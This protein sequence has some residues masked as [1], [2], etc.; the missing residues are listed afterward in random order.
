MVQLLVTNWTP[1]LPMTAPSLVGRYVRTDPLDWTKDVPLFGRAL[2]GN[3][4]G[5]I[6]KRLQWYG[7]P[8]LETEDDLALLLQKIE[9]SMG[10]CVNI[11]R[12]GKSKNQEGVVA[13]MV[14]FIATRAEHGYRRYEWKCDSHNIPL[15][16][17]AICYGFTYEGCFRQHVVTANKGNNR[18][19]MDSEWPQRK[20]A[21]KAWLGTSNF[22]ADGKQKQRIQD[23]QT[24]KTKEPAG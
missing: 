16:N 23:F 21:M 10:C 13:G 18:D 6:S 19:M 1:R 11:F 15:G 5:T 3:N 17:A 20:Q 7:L 12:A 14:S 2:G 8:D 9:E 22:D 24:W 4:G